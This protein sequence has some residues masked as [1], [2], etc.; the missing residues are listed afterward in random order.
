MT[1]HPP[2][3]PGQKVYLDAVFC[4][5]KDCYVNQPREGPLTVKKVY[6]CGQHWRVSAASGNAH[7]DADARNFSP[8]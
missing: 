6:L 1:C 4:D 3:I 2:F 5:T 7:Y 8:T